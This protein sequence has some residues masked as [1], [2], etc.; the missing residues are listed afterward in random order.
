MSD[1]PRR[2]QWQVRYKQWSID[3]T[4]QDGVIVRC[5]AYTDKFVGRETNHLRQWAK[6]FPG[7]EITAT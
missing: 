2:I 5:S 1:I 6:Q 7:M 3:I 4:E